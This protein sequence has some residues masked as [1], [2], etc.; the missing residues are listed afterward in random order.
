MR[1]GLIAA[2]V[3]LAVLAGLGFAGW[4]A[5]RAVYQ[6]I[7]PQQCTVVMEQGTT[8]LSAE[9][10]RNAAVIVAVSAERG[11]PE[12]AAVIALATAYQESDL[13]NLDYGDRDS[14]G[15]FQQRPSYGWG[16]EEEILD[17]WYSSARFYE[18]LVTFSGWETGDIND[19]AQ[20]VQRSGF[21]EAYRQ[22]VDKA[23]A[24][25]GTLR[26]SRPEGIACL[27]FEDSPT[28]DRTVF[29]RV[30]GTLGSG[31]TVAATDTGVILTSADETT[32][33]A[34]AQLAVANTY[35]SGLTAVVVG[36]REW[37]SAEG[38]WRD[39]SE[40]APTGTAVLTLG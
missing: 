32:L 8:T 38:A 30:L 34:A 14:L 29:D 9:Q 21:P 25:A 16:T 35:A 12:R 22:H 10:A 18:E 33:W 6:R 19:V 2:L 4:K 11:L 24:V 15:L 13:R 36:D 28:P 23:T 17:P 1:R 20:Q 26:G 37:T 5:Y 27:S 7:T 31:V 39:A 40:P 3:T